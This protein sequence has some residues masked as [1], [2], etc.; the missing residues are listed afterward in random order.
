EGDP[1]PIFG[2]GVTLGRT[3]N[4]FL[5]TTG[6]V[7]EHHELLLHGRAEEWTRVLFHSE[8]AAAGCKRKGQGNAR[9]DGDRGARR[10][11]PHAPFRLR[12]HRSGGGKHAFAVVA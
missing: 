3:E 2:E 11:V 7:P 6:Q 8:N 10:E 5:L 9:R 4:A 12:L 1:L